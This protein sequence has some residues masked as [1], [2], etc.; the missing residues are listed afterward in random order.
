MSLE[1]W[2]DRFSKSPTGNSLVVQWLGHGLSVPGVW[3]QSPVRELRF[4]KL[5]SVAKTKIKKRK[6]KRKALYTVLETLSWGPL[7]AF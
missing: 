5:R 1:S 3:V 7:E 4:C 6:K 2:V